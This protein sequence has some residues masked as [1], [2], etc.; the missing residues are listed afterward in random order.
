MN[1]DKAHFDRHPDGMLGLWLYRR[2]CSS[3]LYVTSGAALLANSHVGMGAFAVLKPVDSNGDQV[4]LKPKP[5]KVGDTVRFDEETF[6]VIVSIDA[7][8]IASAIMMDLGCVALGKCEAE[9]FERA[10]LSEL[11]RV[12][13][14]KIAEI[15][16]IATTPLPF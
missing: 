7:N 11:E 15:L 13:L 2:A 4:E 16:D 12:Q 1:V 5:L 14:R 3:A 10:K 6:G 8:G 9:S